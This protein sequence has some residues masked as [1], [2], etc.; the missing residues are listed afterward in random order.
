MCHGDDGSGGLP[1]APNYTNPEIVAEL[2]SNSGENLCIVAEGQKSM[3]GWKETMT[4]QQMWE[5]L[6]YIYSFG[7]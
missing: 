2:R 3:P 7:K 4:D 6:T 1:G 5:V